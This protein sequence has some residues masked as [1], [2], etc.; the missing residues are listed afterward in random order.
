MVGREETEENGTR[1]SVALLQMVSEGSDQDF[2]QD[3]NIAKGDV[4]CRRAA[5]LGAD[6][7]LFP[8]R[9]RFAN[10]AIRG[11]SNPG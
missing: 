10:A 4:F 11:I 8:E 6:I 1:I 7:A 3:A 9:R 2:D 5:A